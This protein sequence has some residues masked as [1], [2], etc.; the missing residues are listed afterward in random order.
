MGVLKTSFRHLQQLGGLSVESGLR[1]RV[2]DFGLRGLG[3]YGL[4]LKL[5]GSGP[6]Y[7]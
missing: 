3:F 5:R 7:D 6:M 1:V 2:E 4:G